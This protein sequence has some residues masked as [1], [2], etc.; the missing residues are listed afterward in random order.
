MND[1]M[2]QWM[3]GKRREVED[4][5][6]KED[7][8][9]RIGRL[10]DYVEDGRNGVLTLTSI[11][12]YHIIILYPLTFLQQPF[13]LTSSPPQSAT[14]PTPFHPTPDYYCLHLRLCS[15]HPPYPSQTAIP[16]TRLLL[17]PS[18][19][20]ST[21]SNSQNKYLRGHG[22]IHPL[23][24]FS[25]CLLQAFLFHHIPRHYFSISYFLL[26][27]F[28]LCMHPF[29]PE[30]IPQA[31]NPTPLSPLTPYPIFPNPPIRQLYPLI[32]P[33]PRTNT[34]SPPQLSSPTAPLPCPATYYWPGNSKVDG[35]I[36]W[37]VA[38]ARCFKLRKPLAP[39]T[40]QQIVS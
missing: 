38:P 7:E 26:S 12:L 29:I 28:I 22:P 17:L 23:M 35:H 8:A 33:P 20:I 14:K 30:Q 39:E 27:S 15:G 1:G 18:V 37:R 6:D 21:F 24:F 19:T 10:G 36:D 4:E 13:L 31:P 25:L 9:D 2:V 11:S 3:K 16:Y 32:P 40:R 34:F 5:R